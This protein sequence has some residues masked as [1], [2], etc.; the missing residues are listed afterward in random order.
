M[1]DTPPADELP[2]PSAF[3]PDAGAFDI[4]D[5]DDR[6]DPDATE[7]DAHALE[8]V[9]LTGDPSLEV[10]EHALDRNAEHGENPELIDEGDV[11]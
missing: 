11:R 9:G 2:D 6:L 3:V 1:T 4:P 8:L 7:L 5:P 10:V